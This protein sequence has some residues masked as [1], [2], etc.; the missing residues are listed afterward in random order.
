MCEGEREDEG[1]GERGHA[2][3]RLASE[4]GWIVLHAVLTLTLTLTLTLDR[5]PCCARAE[6]SISCTA[7]GEDESQERQWWYAHSL[8]GCGGIRHQESEAAMHRTE[9]ESVRV[10]R[11]AM[12]E[13]LV[14]P[15]SSSVSPSCRRHEVE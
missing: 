15:S 14:R 7:L 6:T 4:R 8:T 3:G 13:D 11:T 1:Q 9:A 5:P 2:R 10:G 12:V